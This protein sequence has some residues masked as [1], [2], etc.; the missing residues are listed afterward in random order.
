VVNIDFGRG[1]GQ[2]GPSLGLNNNYR[3]NNSGRQFEPRDGEYSIAKT[4]AGMNPGWYTVLNHTPNDPDG[5]MMVVNSDNNPGIFYESTAPINLC[6]N[7]TYEFAA[8]VSNILRDLN[9]NKPNI[10]FFI[11]TMNN[12]VLRTFNTGDIP[13]GNPQWKQHGFLFQ[14]TNITQVKIRMVN[15]GPGGPGNDLALDDITFRACGP[16]ITTKLNNTSNTTED[17]CEGESATYSFSAD[18]QG[19]A[20]LQYQWQV[21]RDYG[22][23]TDIPGKSSTSMQISFTNAEKGIY[24]YR[25]TAAEP[26][27]FNSVN[28]RTVSPTL[29]I[30]VNP[31]PE[32]TIAS[33]ILGC[34]GDNITLNLLSSGGT[35]VWTGPNGFTSAQKSPVI[36]NATAAMRGVYKVLVTSPFG[37]ISTTETTVDIIARPVAGVG[38]PNP[39]VCSGSPVQLVAYGGTSYKWFPE[40]GLSDSN[41]AN[42]IASPTRNTLYTVAV[43]N[44]TCETTVLVDVTVHQ[45]PVAI[46]GED[47]K[48]LA[49]NSI[50]IEGTAEGDD[51]TYFW[52]PS[53]DLDDP[54]KLNPVASPKSDRTYTFHVVSN[55][56]CVTATSDVFIKVYEKVEVPSSFSPNG[57]GINDTWSIVA[58]DT[59]AEPK[60]RVINRYGELLFESNGY[61]I[62]WDGKY[63]NSDVPPGV[64]YYVINLNTDLK[65]LSGSL[66]VIR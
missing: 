6:P 18:V 35:Y 57:D 43:S 12:Q 42:P 60:V 22:G 26:G 61:K 46:T 11:L 56:G 66:T 16:V 23:W 31:L 4:T 63:K 65:P 41:I 55:K 1:P 29:T 58:I 9:G 30:K 59:F 20:T 52:S 5:Y 28:C 17:L 36:Q 3:Y 64:Y 38:N 13:N 21:S 44:G 34:I 27:N 25:F 37:C 33:N 62:P 7:T 47:K 39:A 45:N 51:I 53:E 32:L 8:W 19:S 49:G 40:E 50:M 14:T 15:N 48:I 2:F 24:Q 54:T 10:T